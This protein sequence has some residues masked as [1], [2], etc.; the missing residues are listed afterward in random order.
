MGKHEESNFEW[1]LKPI[2]V[3]M[4][5][6]GQ[7][8]IIDQ[9]K[10]KRKLYSLLILVIGV[11]ILLIN[12]VINIISFKSV[13]NLYPRP[14]M[15]LP[16]YLQLVISHLF[17]DLMVIGLPLSFFLMRIVNRRWKDLM[18]TLQLIQSYMKLSKKFHRKIRCC[19]FVSI[20]FFLLVSFKILQ[21]MVSLFNRF[22]CF[23]R[24]RLFL[25]I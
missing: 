1:S 23:F 2:T 15:T 20:F 22:I 11:A 17:H 25:H 7:E 6:F 8:I 19:V 24:M 13:Y 14:H 5:I 18:S 21:K 12:V 4:T 3:L 9:S 16:M 10:P